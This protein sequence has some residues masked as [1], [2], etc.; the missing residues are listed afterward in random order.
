VSRGDDAGCRVAAYGCVLDVRTP[1][2]PATARS[3]RRGYRASGNAHVRLTW[4]FPKKVTRRS[5]KDSP[6]PGGAIDRPRC[7][8]ITGTRHRGARPPGCP[9]RTLRRPR[10]SPTSRPTLTNWQIDVGGRMVRESD[11]VG[12]P[13]A[14][15]QILASRASSDGSK[16][17][18]GRIGLLFVSHTSHLCDPD[19]PVAGLRAGDIG[20]GSRSDEPGNGYGGRGERGGPIGTRRLPQGNEAAGPQELRL[21]RYACQIAISK[22]RYLHC[23][24]HC[25]YS[26]HPRSDERGLFAY[27]SIQRA[28]R[29]RKTPGLAAESARSPS[30]SLILRACRPVQGCGLMRPR[31]C[32]LVYA[33]HCH[34]HVRCSPLQQGSVHD[35]E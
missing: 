19:C 15:L 7:M 26:R 24:V 8:I 11:Y 31:P 14:V 33:L 18:Y 16:P 17:P 12:V 22:R 4:K 21:L 2:V 13:R 23:Q 35:N 25:A 34:G 30:T 3:S 1:T 28:N 20:A 10:F 27:G 32:A 29:T 9:R 6:N 5:R